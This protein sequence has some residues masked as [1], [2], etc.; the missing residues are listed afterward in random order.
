MTAIPNAM[1]AQSR[2]ATAWRLVARGLPALAAMLTNSRARHRLR[3]YQGCDVRFAQDIA[4]SAGDIEWESGRR[5]W[6]AVV[7]P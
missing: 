7:R 2:P 5:P 4:M 1:L 6:Q 3:V